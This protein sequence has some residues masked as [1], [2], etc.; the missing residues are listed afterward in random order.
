ML[1]SILI[2]NLLLSS[3]N[4]PKRLKFFTESG[5]FLVIAALIS[6]GISIYYE[7][8]LSNYKNELIKLELKEFKIQEWLTDAPETNLKYKTGK[9]IYGLIEGNSNFYLGKK[10]YYFNLLTN[11]PATIEVAIKDIEIINNDYLNN[12][13]K[14]EKIKKE[15][16]IIND[17]VDKIYN[18]FPEE[19]LSNQKYIENIENLLNNI[20]FKKI[21][22]NLDQSKYNILQINLYFQEY[23]NI[24]DEKKEVLKKLIVDTTKTSTNAILYAFLLQLII[25]SLVQIFELKELS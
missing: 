9:F 8:K 16:Q 5:I 18:K 6:S 12:K 21:K 24:V 25:F 3:I 10:R 17:F 23:N 4:N 19:L 15:N 22:N 7:Q 20:P 14:I 13:Y 1:K 11:Y 2:R